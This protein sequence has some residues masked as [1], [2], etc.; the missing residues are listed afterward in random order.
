VPLCFLFVKNNLKNIEYFKIIFI[1][2]T[3]VFITVFWSYIILDTNG[4]SLASINT[5][6][7]RNK[8]DTVPLIS[9]H[10]IYASMIFSIAIFLLLSLWGEINNYLL[11][12]LFTVLILNVLVLA[13]KMAIV[14]LFIIIGYF[15]FKRAQKNYFKIIVVFLITISAIV[16]ILFIPNLRHRFNE[17]ARPNTYEKVIIWNSTSIRKGIYECSVTLLKKQWLFGYGIGDVQD[18]LNNCYEVKSE[19]LFNGKYNSHNQYLSI[20]LGTGFLG[21]FIFLFM[22]GYNFNLSLR[23]NDMLFQVI[24]IFF[25]INFLTEN[26]LQRQTGVILFIFLI[27]VFGWSNFNRISI[28]DLEKDE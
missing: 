10:T 5:E 6:I 4:I 14:S 1:F 16:S 24:I 15:L 3:V 12:S 7:L 25:A 18:N 22:L 20:W 17:I 2:S 13:S 28:I 27:N 9:L 26:L 21:F 19:V 11:L 8:I 23:F